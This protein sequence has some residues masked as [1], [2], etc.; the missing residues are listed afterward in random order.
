MFDLGEH[1]GGSKQSQLHDEDYVSRE[2]VA[3]HIAISPPDVQLSIDHTWYDYFAYRD[4]H[5]VTAIAE[6]P[7]D[8][9]LS[10][11][12]RADRPKGT[13]ASAS[14]PTGEHQVGH[15]LLPQSMWSRSKD[16]LGSDCEP[17]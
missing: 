14:A 15:V 7:I 12:R 17:T 2:Y 16:I 3:Q 10:P 11:V 6:L 1:R 5:S 9:D 13:A 8:D 4:I